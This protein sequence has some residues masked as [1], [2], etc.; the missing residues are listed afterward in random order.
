[1]ASKEFPYRTEIVSDRDSFLILRQ[2]HNESIEQTLIFSRFS[3]NKTFGIVNAN[4]VYRERNVVL[5]H[6]FSPSSP[7]TLVHPAL[8]NRRLVFSSRLFFCALEPPFRDTL[9]FHF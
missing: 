8:F 9:K 3:K 6:L 1:M 7:R 5:S 2:S 4:V